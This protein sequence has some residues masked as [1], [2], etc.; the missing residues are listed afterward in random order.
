MDGIAHRTIRIAGS[1]STFR[2]YLYLTAYYFISIVLLAAGVLKIY[3]PAPLLGTLE[4]LTFINNSFAILIATI[5]PIIEIAIGILLLTGTK[6]KISVVSA[7]GLFW[8]F[9]A[10]SVY[11]YAAGLDADCGCFGN[12][13][14]SDFGAGMILRNALFAIVASMLLLYHKKNK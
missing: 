2:R 11:G 4:L 9:F 3:D 12:V 6:A 8:F 5:L 14:A 1:S 10:F 13:I 7:A